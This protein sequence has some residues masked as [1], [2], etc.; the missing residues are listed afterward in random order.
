M[1]ASDRS[2]TPSSPV[3]EQRERERAPP[4]YGARMACTLYVPRCRD[5]GLSGYRSVACA[6]VAD[7]SCIVDIGETG[8]RA[9]RERSRACERAH[10]PFSL[11]AFRTGIPRHYQPT[12]PLDVLFH[13]RILCISVSLFLSGS[14]ITCSFFNCCSVTSRNPDRGSRGSMAIVKRFDR[15]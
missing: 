5:N 9:S 7:V 10:I 4:S 15:R 3:E 8:L 11:R 2:I 6:R 14:L 13:S 1:A 12:P